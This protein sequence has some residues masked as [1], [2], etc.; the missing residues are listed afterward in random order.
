MGG[1]QGRPCWHQPAWVGLGVWKRRQSH[2][3]HKLPMR[4]EPSVQLDEHIQHAGHRSPD[5]DRAVF[6]SAT[7]AAA[8]SPRA[9]AISSA[10]LG[11]CPTGPNMREHLS[12]HGMCRRHNQ[13]VVSHLGA[14]GGSKQWRPLSSS[15]Y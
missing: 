8:I 10:A 6:T 12:G 13:R 14:N 1:R 4:S 5:P 3:T 7:C 15:W 9:A 2:A 11:C